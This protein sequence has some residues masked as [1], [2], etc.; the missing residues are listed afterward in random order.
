MHAAAVRLELRIPDGRSLK[1][2][3]RVLKA[4]MAQL[5]QVF[6]VAVS[7][8]GFQDQ[9]KRATVGV[10]LVAPQ[11]SHLERLVHAVHRAVLDRPD[12]EL[13]EIGIAYLEES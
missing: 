8:V 2:K 4:L 10:A 13:L 7:E 6:G 5:N 11:S 12:V 3:R 1:A 9:W